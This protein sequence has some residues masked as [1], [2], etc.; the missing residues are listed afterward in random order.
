MVAVAAVPGNRGSRGVALVLRRGEGQVGNVSELRGKTLGESRAR[1][2][3]RSG[4][5][6]RHGVAVA[7]RRQSSACA[8]GVAPRGEAE[9][10]AVAGL[11]EPGGGEAAWPGGRRAA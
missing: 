10:V 4:R 9:R 11:G 8:H 1:E 3:A 2:G 7:P 5:P 6:A